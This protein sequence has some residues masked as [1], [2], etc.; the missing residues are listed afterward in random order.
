MKRF[1]YYIDGAIVPRCDFEK[2]VPPHVVRKIT[3]RVP[4][5]M[6]V[7]P[8]TVGIGTDALIIRNK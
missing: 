5:G 8:Q 3:R 2:Y 1:T 6:P 4:V 7:R